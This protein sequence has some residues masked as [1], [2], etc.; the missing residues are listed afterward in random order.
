VVTTAAIDDMK[1]EEKTFGY[2]TQLVKAIVTLVSGK[3][4]LSLTFP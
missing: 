1:T 2:T 4:D 3:K